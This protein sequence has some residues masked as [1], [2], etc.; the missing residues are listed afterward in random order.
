LTLGNLTHAPFIISL[1]NGDDGIYADAVI[2]STSAAHNLFSSKLE[3]F[4][5]T[6]PTIMSFPYSST[7]SSQ[8]AH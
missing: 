3:N 2:T 8:A 7:I 1:L 4:H 5:F 6:T